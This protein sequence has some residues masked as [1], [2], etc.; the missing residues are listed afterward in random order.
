MRPGDALIFSAWLVHAAPNNL[1]PRRRSAVS[2]RWLGDDVRWQPHAAADPSV[3]QEDVCVQPGELVRDDDYF[4]V[5]WTS[6]RD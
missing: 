6:L 1:S 4:P 5:A 2:T 3:R